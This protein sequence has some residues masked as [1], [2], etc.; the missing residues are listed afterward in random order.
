MSGR[1][2]PVLLSLWVG[3]V[4]VSQ[5]LAAPSNFH[6]S[7]PQQ[8]SCVENGSGCRVCRS[9][10]FVD[11][12]PVVSQ[13]VSAECS[14]L[15][16][17]AS[18]P[19]PPG[20]QSSN[21]PLHQQEGYRGW[22]SQDGIHNTSYQG[23]YS[24]NP[25]GVGYPGLATIGATLATHAMQASMQWEGMSLRDSL[26]S[27]RHQVGQEVEQK[28]KSSDSTR[29]LLAQSSAIGGAGSGI[30][31]ISSR[32]RNE[33]QSLQSLL[34]QSKGERGPPG[35]SA[36]SIPRDLEADLSSLLK[37]EA[38]SVRES[39]ETGLTR[40]R[41]ERNRANQQI[42]DLD[43][44][45]RV[46]ETLALAENLACSEQGA[47]ATDI[48]QSEKE[49][50]ISSL[51]EATK[52][53]R[54]RSNNPGE[55]AE[56][57]APAG[58]ATE[59]RVRE[60]D[61]RDHA[62]T[63]RITGART[64]I[65]GNP[66]RWRHQSLDLAVVSQ[67]VSHSQFWSGAFAEGEAFQQI[68]V[69]LTDLALSV[70]PGVSVGKDAYEL[71]YGHNLVTGEELSGVERSF[72]VVGILSL[73]TANTAKGIGKGLLRIGGRL[74]VALEP[75]VKQGAEV[76]GSAGKIERF[77]PLR[78]GPLHAIAEGSGTVAD[79]FRSGS[80][81]EVITKSPVK[82][83]RAYGGNAVSLGRYWSRVKPSGPYQAVLDSALDPL[84]G[85]SSSSWIELTV[86]VG[87]KFY[88]GFASDVFLKTNGSNVKVGHLLGGGSQVYFP[89]KIL[90][91]FEFKKGVF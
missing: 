61:D 27:F 33:A 36:G 56:V 5:G 35:A 54:Y 31:G 82:L 57:L 45:K 87:T 67:E 49:A 37:P 85:N 6:H 80:Y 73:G 50:A 79:T 74:G 75:F 29:A 47:D 22:I 1:F 43:L 53:D 78:H 64:V 83:Y 51:L 28:Q 91:N 3:V 32:N 13:F 90:D 62:L 70:L 10:T 52:S 7:S 86:P 8:W 26:D 81:F 11:M 15:P 76:V 9:V 44:R 38:P 63:E 2:L 40:I 39:C 84:W 68:A 17:S 48:A 34:A 46:L 24:Q 41:A 66:D 77:H 18:I 30:S 58:K 65:S 88:E 71:V 12:Q 21:I 16:V 55:S 60:F 19:A 23:Q 14:A 72:A 25:S 4:S 89:E 69:S 59:K 20:P 42:N